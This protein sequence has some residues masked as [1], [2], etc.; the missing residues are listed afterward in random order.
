MIKMCCLWCH[1]VEAVFAQT[2]PLIQCVLDG[3]NVCILAYGQTGSG[4]TY[5]IMGTE[6]DKMGELHAKS[7]LNYR[8]LTELFNLSSKRKETFSYSVSVQMLEIYNEKLRDLLAPT[9]QTKE[10]PF[11]R[12]IFLKLADFLLF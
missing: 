5:T 2:K 7:G 3:Y 9:G 6:P 12:H 10:Y 8:A 1:F 11:L 4:K